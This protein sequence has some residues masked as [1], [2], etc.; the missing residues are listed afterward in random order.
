MLLNNN[1]EAQMQS[2]FIEKIVNNE[3]FSTKECLDDNISFINGLAMQKFRPKGKEK[4]L[5]VIKI[6]ELSQGYCDDNSEYCTSRID[7]THIITNGDLVFSWSGSL[8]VSFWTSCTAG[9]NQHLFKVV[10]EAYPKWFIYLWTKHHLINFQRIAENKG[11]TFG[12]IKREDLHN[13]KIKVLNDNEFQYLN[14]IFT[15]LLDSILANAS[16]ISHLNKLQKVLLSTLS[17]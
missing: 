17:R 13:A 14:K 4:S 11:T 1:L 12:H 5:P 7:D 3:A 15:P 10:S 8:Q 9:L 6:R 16:E 2:L